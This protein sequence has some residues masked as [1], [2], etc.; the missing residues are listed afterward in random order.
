M[1]VSLLCDA[2]I[3]CSDCFAIMFFRLDVCYSLFVKSALLLANNALLAV[4][5]HL[6]Q[7]C[8]NCGNLILTYLL[9]AIML[10]SEL[11]Q[12]NMM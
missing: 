2:L 8:V 3:L 12:I 10:N 6:F 1:G 5:I 9:N 4:L 7:I 11:I